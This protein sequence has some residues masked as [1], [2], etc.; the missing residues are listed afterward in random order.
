MAHL[1]AGQEALQDQWGQMLRG[2]PRTTAWGEAGS[3]TPSTPQPS[4]H[5]H[6]RHEFHPT[7]QTSLSHSWTH[8]LSL[9]SGGALRARK[10]PVT[11]LSLL[12]RRPDQSDETRVTL[13]KGEVVTGHRDS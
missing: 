5:P 10:A 9:L 12:S 13:D 6:L 8:R 1:R 7:P 2:C 3:L 4:S 11:L